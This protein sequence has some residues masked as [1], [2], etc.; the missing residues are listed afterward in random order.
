[1]Q[2]LSDQYGE[3]RKLVF[4][5]RYISASIICSAL[6]LVA[7]GANRPYIG[8]EFAEWLNL[9]SFGPLS[10]ATDCCGSFKQACE[11]AR[12]YLH[13]ENQSVVLNL[14]DCGEDVRLVFHLCPISSLSA[15]RQFAEAL[16]ATIV[17]L[18]RAF[19][20]DTTAPQSVEFCH[21]A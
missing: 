10:L 12:K 14:E 21:T 19:L 20:G 5:S 13:V 7:A 6:E 11:L 18:G 9:R 4:S 16:L 17:R 15:P 1:D 2:L 3:L 8:V